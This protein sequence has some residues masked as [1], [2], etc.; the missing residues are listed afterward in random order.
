[1][2]I[3][4][5]DDEP[6]ILEELRYLCKDM[7]DLYIGGS[8]SNPADALEY[9][10]NH[11][12]D[13]AFLDI[14]MP[15]IT[16]LELLG[17]MREIQKNIQAA[18]VTAYN[19]YALEAFRKDACDYLLK[20]FGPEEVEHALE[21]ARRILGMDREK[22][23]AVE[24]RTFG[25]FD[26]FLNSRPVNFSSRKA[27]ELLAFLVARKG[28]IVEM[29]FAIE[30]LWENEPFDSRSKAKLRKALMNLRNTLREYGI[31][32]L[33]HGERGRLWLEAE[34]VGCDYFRLL[35]GDQR[36]ASQF[37]GEFMSE[38]SWSEPYLP[39]LERQARALREE[40]F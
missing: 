18:F 22:E 17:K 38:Y 36:A 2:R 16:G 14:S 30:T 21:K 24:I 23:E 4:L 29:E 39:A 12:V 5:V 10:R 31:P 26:L 37:Q 9:V 11:P 32:W 1:M 25:R 8:F 27:K 13:F 35:E 20:P 3:I 7:K 15:G 28:G 19:Q 33:V 40:T 6:L 34:G